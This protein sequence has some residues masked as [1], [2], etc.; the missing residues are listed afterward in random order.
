MIRKEMLEAIEVSNL[1]KIYSLEALGAD[2]TE[3]Q[4]VK[5]AVEHDQLLVICHQVYKGASID[6][7]ISL[8]N[9]FRQPTILR[10][11]KSWKYVNQTQRKPNQD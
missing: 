4:C 3:P 9:E 2:S 5:A 8:A 10:W 1:E 7:V 6:T 11:A